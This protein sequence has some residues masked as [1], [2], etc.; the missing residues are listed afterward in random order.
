VPTVH[1]VVTW[2]QTS[3]HKRGT[4]FDFHFED[5]ESPFE[6]SSCMAGVCE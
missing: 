3:D 2:A 6:E 1:D 4:Q 5:Y